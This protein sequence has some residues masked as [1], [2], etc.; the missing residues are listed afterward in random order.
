MKIAIIGYGKMG[1]VIKSI[2]E[3]RN[4]KVVTIDPSAPADFKEINQASIGDVD[5]CIDFTHPS[6]LV[7]NVKKIS[8]LKKNVVVGTTGW[9]NRIDEVKRIVD[10]NKTGLIWAGNFS[11]GMNVFFIKDFKK[12]ARSLKPVYTTAL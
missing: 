5:L 6:V 2:A 4:H 1:K 3:S 7:D 10:E 11:I 9:Y 12:T 8:G